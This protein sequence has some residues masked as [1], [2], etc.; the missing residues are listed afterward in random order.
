MR[1]YKAIVICMLV[2][3]WLAACHKVIGP[4][5]ARNVAEHSV[6][7]F[8]E[9]HG[10]AASAFRMV[11][12]DDSGSVVD[13]LFTYWANVNVKHYVVSVVVDRYGRSKVHWTVDSRH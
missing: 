2:S 10:I 9:Q 5:E 8:A 11:E 7:V 1:Q 3:L 13:W 4:I 6:Q 12:Q